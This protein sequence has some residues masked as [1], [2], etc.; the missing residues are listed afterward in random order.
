MRS[1]SSS[2]LRES[3]PS[4]RCYTS[5]RAAKTPGGG[6]V[7]TAADASARGPRLRRPGSALSP[8]SGMGGSGGVGRRP[9]RALER[10]DQR[11]SSARRPAGRRHRGRHVGGGRHGARCHARAREVL[12]VPRAIASSPRCSARRR[13][14]RRQARAPARAHPAGTGATLVAAAA[15]GASLGGPEQAAATT[16]P[17]TEAAAA[18]RADATALAAYAV[19]TS[20]MRISS[21]AARP[22]AA[23]HR[24]AT[25]FCCADG[26][27]RPGLHLSP[28][29]GGSAVLMFLGQGPAAGDVPRPYAAVRSAA[30]VWGDTRGAR[31]GVTVACSDIGLAVDLTGNAYAAWSVSR[32]RA[33]V[34]ASRGRCLQPR[35]DDGGNCRTPRVA[36]APGGGGVLLGW[37]RRVRADRTV[38]AHHGVDAPGLHCAPRDPA[39]GMTT[40]LESLALA[41][42]SAASAVVTETTGTGSAQRFGVDV[43]ER[44]TAATPWTTQNVRTGLTEP[45]GSPELAMGALG[46]IALWVEGTAIVARA[47]ITASRACSPWPSRGRSASASSR[48]TPCGRATPGRRS[49]TWCGATATARASAA[50]RCG[51]LLPRRHLPCHGGGAG[52]RRQRGAAD[53]RGR[54]RATGARRLRDGGLGDRDREGPAGT[55]RVPPSNPSVPGAVTAAIPGAKPVR[56]RCTVPG[57]A[58]ALVPG[59]AT[60]GKR[61]VVRVTSRDLAGLPHLRASTLRTL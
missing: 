34:G 58:T 13:R 16:A 39:R 17:I 37:I 41:D 61:V 45:V 32:A 3:V 43:L 30:G 35:A 56:F 24:P 59:T 22:A 47:P 1:S 46:A 40:T 10:E 26:H 50:P 53:V 2:P 27:A 7:E 25:S 23:G 60:R 20:P 54:R 55:D 48:P 42:S 28:L 29:P 8:T 4:R 12:R 18:L 31:S 38:A 15:V 11:G 21:A 52:R 5:R 9:R 49:P 33:H 44:V 14:R 51:R 36:S 57:R 19:A 6:R